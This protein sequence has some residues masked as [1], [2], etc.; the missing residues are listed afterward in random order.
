MLDQVEEVITVVTKTIPNNF[1]EF[2]FELIFNGLLNMR[3]QLRIV[4]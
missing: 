2:I 4:K 3:E 1:P